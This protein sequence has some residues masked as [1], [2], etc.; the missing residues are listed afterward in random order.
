LLLP[1]MRPSSDA[2]SGLA[3]KKHRPPAVAAARQGWP[4]FVRAL[5]RRLGFFAA[6]F[7]PKTNLTKLRKTK[8]PRRLT[9]PVYLQ[10]LIQLGILPPG[11]PEFDYLAQPT[12]SMDWTGLIHL[13]FKFLRFVGI[14]HCQLAA[15][16]VR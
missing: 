5:Q 1:P 12:K 15:D 14:D 6:T 10:Q 13:R 3:W 11:I 7:K 4:L 2:L 8:V 9:C 16:A